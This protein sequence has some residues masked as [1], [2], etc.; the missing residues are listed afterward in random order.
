MRILKISDVFFPRVNGVSTSIETFRR[1][2]VAQGHEVVLVAPAYSRASAEPCE[3]ANPS[4][5]R[6]PARAVPR[7]PED[8]IMAWGGL[9]RALA[10]L[11]PRKFD[12]VHI[13]TPFLAHYAGLGFAR[14]QGTP[15]VATYHTL[16]EE[17]LHHYVPLLPRQITGGL[18]RRFSRS[19]CNQLDAV[20][21]PSSVV[22]TR[23]C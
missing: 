23:C 21:A 10:E 20:I 13:H 8:R 7:D 5:R 3:T 9:R 22:P 16:F 1:D 19:Q 15:V 14:E 17:Y 4:I 12:V 2:L 18:A 6:V 11:A